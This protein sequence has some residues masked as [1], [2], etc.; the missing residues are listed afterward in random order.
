MISNNSLVITNQGVI[1]FKITN[2]QYRNF[3]G[4]WALSI[5]GAKYGKS[6]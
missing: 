1:L 3:Y 2:S 6:N 5:N 4:A